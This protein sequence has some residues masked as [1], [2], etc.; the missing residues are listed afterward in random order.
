[1]RDPAKEIFDSLNLETDVAN[2][3]SGQVENLYIDFKTKQDHSTKD[4]DSDLQKIL[5]KSLAGFANA[6]GGVIIL[7]VDAPQNASPSLKPIQPIVLFE[8]EVNSYI[9]RATSFPVQGVLIKSIPVSGG[10]LGVVIIY[11]PKSDQAPH[12]SMKDK[13]YYQ[14]IGD[15]FLP[16]EHYQIADMFGKRHHPSLAPVVQ[17]SGNVNSRG[18]IELILGVMNNGR[19]VGRF[20]LLNVD[21]YAGFSFNSYGITGNGHFGL[22]PFPSATSLSKYRGGS[23]IV[24]HPNTDLPVTKMEYH[25]QVDAAGNVLH[26]TSDLIIEGQI[27]ADDFPIRKWRVQIPLVDIQGK[28]SNPRGPAIVIQGEIL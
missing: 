17:M 7:G 22:S 10:S 25:C 11:V 27:A 28:V 16:M 24:V 14:R 2:L 23:D 1:M 18:K 3:I 4:V 12:C 9:S 15:S 13:K 5:S 19:A 26:P 8:Q 21:S 6:D 20:L